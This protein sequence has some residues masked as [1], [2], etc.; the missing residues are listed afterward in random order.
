MD[1]DRLDSGCLAIGKKNLKNQWI[2]ACIVKSALYVA[3]DNGG[4][5]VHADTI[6]HIVGSCTTM[7]DTGSTVLVNDSDKGVYA[8]LKN[9]KESDP[10]FNRSGFTKNEDIKIFLGI[11]GEQTVEAGKKYGESG[12]TLL[13]KLKRITQQL[14]VKLRIE[15]IILHLAKTLLT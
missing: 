1:F 15:R 13:E 6:Y 3:E 12:K 14:G 2:N 7:D 4:N 11:Y 9:W 10:V 8:C 5:I